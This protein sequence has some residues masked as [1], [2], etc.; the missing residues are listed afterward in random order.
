[1]S[2]ERPRPTSWPE[3]ITAN[4]QGNSFHVVVCIEV[5]GK[6]NKKELVKLKREDRYRSNI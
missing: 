3:E 5:D 6:E 1:M 2:E 4:L